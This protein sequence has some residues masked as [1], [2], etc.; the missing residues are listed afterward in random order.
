MADYVLI[1]AFGP[2]QSFIASARRSRDLWSGSWLLS[3]ISKAAALA[4][5]QEQ[6][7]LIFPAILPTSTS[8]ELQANSDLS[9]A[10]K[11]QAVV[12]GAELARVKAIADTAKA[13]AK[14]R[15]VAIAAE[16]KNKIQRNAL[17]NEIWHK[18]L[19]DYIE[20]YAAWAEIHADAD[21]SYALAVEQANA[22]LAARKATRDFLPNATTPDDS[23]FIKLPKSSLDGARETVLQEGKLALSLRRQLGL[24]QSENLDCVAVVKRLGGKVE[25]FTP[26]SRITAHAWLKLLADAEKAALCAA[27]EP[28]IGMGICTRVKGN[29][30]IYADFPYDGQLLYPAR[31]TVAM[32]EAEQE[33]DPEA[34]A[35]LSELQNVLLP[36]WRRYGE[37]CAYGALLLADGDKMGELLDQV[38]T[39]AGHQAV[40]QA[41]SEFAGSVAQTVRNY[42]GHAIYAG[43]DDVLALVPLAQAQD[44]ANAL[45][46]DFAEKLGKVAEALQVD[47]RP[48]LSVGLAIAHMMQPF[49]E[50][51]QLASRA[52]KYAKGD[53]FGDHKRNALAFTV[54]VRSG[55]TEDIRFRWDDAKGLAC[56]D[57]WKKGF[58]EK[59]LS[60]R[61]AYDT[62]AIDLRTHFARQ[63][64]S[65]TTEPCLSPIQA[66][67][68]TRMLQRARTT[69]GKQ[70]DTKM[71][72]KLSARAGQIGL[73]NL[74]KELIVARWLEA[75]T[76]RDTGER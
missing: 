12:R 22:A 45:R 29:G 16:V 43:G 4:L 17:R 3:E 40:T 1:L 37:P 36:L 70:L 13:A 2:V 39:L 48:T 18:Q 57:T 26:F 58:K 59:T 68:F 74:A 24:G 10:N 28:L 54:A 7:T 34:H 15:F 61:V 49:A 27:Y 6:A 72:E 62:R 47:A 69:G 76:S 67:E 23:L 30:G 53:Q 33:Q 51:R 11:V 71:Q 38:R 19:D 64:C 14:A 46:Q 5:H 66:A 8:A 31:L 56:F 60:S 75:K 25:Q 50:I 35:A 44:C 20:A 63:T 65:D 9:V 42:Q 55:A 52:E 32:G 21:T 41:L 73:E